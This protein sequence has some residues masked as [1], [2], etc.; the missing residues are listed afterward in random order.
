MNLKIL[1]RLIVEA[2]DVVKLVTGLVRTPKNNLP[3]ELL[4]I[5]EQRIRDRYNKLSK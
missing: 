5:A 4:E 3:E 1:T 2:S